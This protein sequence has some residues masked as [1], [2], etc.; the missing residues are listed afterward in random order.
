LDIG[1]SVKYGYDS[2]G[3]LISVTDRA[4][5]YPATSQKRRDVPYAYPVV[6]M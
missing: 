2:N 4:G 6:A 3:N 5:W 1:N